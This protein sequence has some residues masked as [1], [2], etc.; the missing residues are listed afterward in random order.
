VRKPPR[1]SNFEAVDEF[2]ERRH[3]QRDHD[4]AIEDALRAGEHPGIS[5]REFYSGV[6]ESMHDDAVKEARH[7]NFRKLAVL[8]RWGW[9]LLPEAA[10]LIADK[11]TGRFLPEGA[12]LV[13]D[14]H[15]GKLRR[16]R[17]RSKKPLEQRLLD[18]WLPDAEAECDDIVS[19]LEE[20]YAEDVKAEDIKARA[21]ILAAKKYEEQG[22]TDS[23]LKNYIERQEGDRRRLTPKPSR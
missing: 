17:G 7:G 8:L 22:I 3:D 12:P 19:F 10:S 6:I 16:G 15:T 18:S 23:K 13:V 14:E 20:H 2:V 21:L 1:W 5:Q 4:E 9:R 11:L